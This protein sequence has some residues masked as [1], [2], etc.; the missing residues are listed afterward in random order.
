[1]RAGFKVCVILPCCCLPVFCY[2]THRPR[3][4]LRQSSSGLIDSLR[5]ADRKLKI[6]KFQGYA[7]LRSTG[8]STLDALLIVA[9]GTLK[10][11][12]GVTSSL[13]QNA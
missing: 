12:E 4:N 13:N 3:S 11:L 5:L 9:K 10:M 2:A 8:V 1:M 6:V 7:S